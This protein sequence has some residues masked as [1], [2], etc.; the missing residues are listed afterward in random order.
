[1][2]VTVH[3]SFYYRSHRMLVEYDVLSEYLGEM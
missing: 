1:M 3:V 2:I